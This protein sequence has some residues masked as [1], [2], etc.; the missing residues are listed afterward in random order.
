MTALA[1]Y[2]S[3]FLREHLPKERRASQHTC[4]SYAQAFQ[5]LLCFASRRLKVNRRRLRSS[6]LMRRSSWHSWSILSE[7]APTRRELV[8]SG[9]PRSTRSSVSWS[10]DC[11]PASI[12]R[13]ESMQFP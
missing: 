1:P 11:R 4:E 12:R 13:A 8:T 10:T 9:S 7:R 2:L 5:L 6:G 3:S